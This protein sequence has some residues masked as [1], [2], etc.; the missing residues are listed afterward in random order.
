MQTSTLPGAAGRAGLAA[1]TVL[2]VDDDPAVRRLLALAVE[3]GGRR[4]LRAGSAREALELLREHEVALVVT[5]VNMPQATGL[6]L[7]AA[8]SA[9]IAPPPVLVVT[10]EADPRTAR[11]ATLLGARKVIEKPFG[12]E[13]LGREIDDALLSR[14]GPVLLAS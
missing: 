4:A 10:G 5:D 1:E 11:A 9:T 12:L 14:A 2:V 7:L 13:E 3:L 8:L 6:D